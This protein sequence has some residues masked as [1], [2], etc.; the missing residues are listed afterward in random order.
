MKQKK[1]YCVGVG[2]VAH[3][4]VLENPEQVDTRYLKGNLFENLIVAE[5]FKDRYRRVRLQ[6]SSFGVTTSEMKSIY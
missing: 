4:L 6:I 5:F 3:L 1:L 2:L